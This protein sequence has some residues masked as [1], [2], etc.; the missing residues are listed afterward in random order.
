M[1]RGPQVELENPAAEYFEEALETFFGIPEVARSAAPTHASVIA[2]V[3]RSLRRATLFSALAAEAYVNT[4]WDIM[5]E[6]DVPRRLDRAETVAKF[7]RASKLGLEGQRLERGR[8]PL[9]LVGELFRRRDRIVHARPERIPIYEYGLR[10]DPVACA[11]WITATAECVLALNAYLAAAGRRGP[12]ETMW[13]VGDEIDL[14]PGWLE[15]E[16]DYFWFGALPHIVVAANDAF[17]ELARAIRT[18]QLGK[19][20]FGDTDPVSEARRRE[21]VLLISPDF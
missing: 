6:G 4:F 15:A 18:D 7:A 2:R 8:R 1:T 10:T 21:A 3:N 9:Q 13:D 20:W 17:M 12:V 11:R 19:A 14:E 5:L 16:Q